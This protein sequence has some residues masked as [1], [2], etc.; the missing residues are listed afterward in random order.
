[1]LFFQVLLFGGYTYAHLVT[2]LRPNWQAIIHVGLIFAALPLMPIMP[3]AAWR[4]Q[5]SDHPVIT[6]LILVPR[7]GGAYLKGN[8]ATH[9]RDIQWKGKNTVSTAAPP[10]SR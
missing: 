3:D 7:R 4:T 10:A 6:I 9:E 8:P 2:R 1:M 5:G